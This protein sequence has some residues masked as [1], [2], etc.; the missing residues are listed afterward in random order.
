MVIGDTWAQNLFR[1][2]GYKRRFS[3]TSKIPIPDKARNEIELIF[4]HKIVQKVEK[5]N[6]SLSLI[7][8]ADQT[9]SKYVPT[10]RYT[11]A[12]KNFK[13]APIAGGADKRAITA[14][15]VE[16]LICKFRPIQSS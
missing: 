1:R 3:T 2:M 7:V 16:K 10:A 8:N 12:E 15:F 9:P 4:M 13:S 11:F 6:I 5:Y 14:T